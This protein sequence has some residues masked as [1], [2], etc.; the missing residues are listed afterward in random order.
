M[1]NIYDN[2]ALM[3]GNIDNVIKEIKR[4]IKNDIDMLFINKDELLKEL[5]ELKKCKDIEIVC[6]DYES[7]RDNYSIDWWCKN[8]IK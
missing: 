1:N 4:E 5:L 6:I 3:I 7:F 2:G 8:D